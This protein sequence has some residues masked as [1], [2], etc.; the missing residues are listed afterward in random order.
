MK[1]AKYISG[2]SKGHFLTTIH[3]Y[4]ATTIPHARQTQQSKLLLNY[5]QV[6]NIMRIL[7]GN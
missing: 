4:G 2:I 6:S 5:R 7:V 1:Y 3:K